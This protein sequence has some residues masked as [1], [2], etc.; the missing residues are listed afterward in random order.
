MSSNDNNSPPRSLNGYHGSMN[1]HGSR[2]NTLNS[3][4]PTSMA[5]NPYGTMNSRVL[6]NQGIKGHFRNF[7][8]SELPPLSPRLKIAPECA[9]QSNL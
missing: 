8:T 9:F 5:M 3:S 1:H 2:I 6:N 7:R 4:P